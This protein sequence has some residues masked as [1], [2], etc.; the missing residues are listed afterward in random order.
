M[1]KHAVFFCAVGLCAQIAC[2]HG[3]VGDRFFPPTIA[4]DDP[5]ATDELLLPS[6]SYTPNPGGS[7]T[8]LGF[9]FDKE[10]FPHFALGIADQRIFQKPAG[11][12]A[13]N[14]W[15]ELSLSA[16][17]EL[18]HNDKYEAIISIGAEADIGG[19]GNSSVGS[20]SFT[21]YIPMIYLGEGFG[22][23]PEAADDFKPFAITAVLGEGIPTEAV[24]AD[25]FQWGIAVEY[26]LPYLQQSVKD[27]GLPEPFKNMIPLVEFAMQ[28]GENRDQ[29]GFTTGTINPGALWETPY[30]Q[31]GA[32]A[33][34]PV[35]QHT[36]THVGAI[37]Q[38]EIFID[39]IFPQVFG[40]P[41]FGGEQ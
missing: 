22:D 30:F 17:F 19:T 23:L 41:L 25:T 12:P 34:V 7:E 16:K 13:V 24:D 27:V 21:T 3:F 26:S 14:G 15:D 20:E 2:A 9:E 33:V 5:F 8:D 37:V 35:N 36:G 40:H 28:T 11:Q 29:R 38:L 32:E 10:I 4:T 1:F 31:L 18:W 6:Y 39:D